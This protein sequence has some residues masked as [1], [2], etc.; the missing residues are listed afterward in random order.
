VDGG[1]K[2]GL[3]VSDKRP[4]RFVYWAR[5]TVRECNQWGAQF[6]GEAGGIAYHYLAD[7]VFEAMPLNTGPVWYP[8]DEGHG[9]R[10]NGHCQHVTFESCRFLDNGRAGVQIVGQDVKSLQ[11][12]QCRFDGNGDG[13]F[14]GLQED[15]LADQEPS[16]DVSFQCPSETTVGREV[17]FLPVGEWTRQPRAGLLWDLGDGPARG[18]EAPCHTYERPGSY[19]VALIVWDRKGYPS[20]AERRVVVGSR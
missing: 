1:Q 14:K 13:A 10:I 8:G 17:Q 16:L 20:R 9:F 4:K 12:V 19:T 3:S 11:F 15:M 6:Q 18:E 5:N 2:I 7:C